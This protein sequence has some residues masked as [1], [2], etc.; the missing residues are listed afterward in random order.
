MKRS[1][2]KRRPL[3]D[4]VLSNLESELKDYRELDGNG[5]YFF[6]QKNGNKSW[7]L[8][9]KKPDGKWSWLG[10]GGYPEIGGKL[11]RKKAQEL[12]A[13]IGKGENPVI[14][15]QERKRKELEN[16]NATFEVLAKEW[17]N[18]K[19]NRWTSNT[20]TR[21]KGALEKHIFPTFGKRLYTT[22]RP[23]EWMNHLKGI[24]QEHKIFEQV[25]R[26]RAMCRDIYDYAKVTG[27]IDYNPL[28]GLQK[29]LEQG[30]KKNMAH[31]DEKELPQLLRAIDNYPTLD[32]RIGLKLLAIL[33]CRPS[34]LRE[35]TWAEF[36]LENA[37]W[38]IPEQ[39][40]K[41]RREHIIPLSTQA[42][43]L[44][45]ELKPLSGRSE[46]LFPSRS[47]SHKPKSDTVFIM[48]LRRLGYEGRQTPHGFRHI[49]STLLNNKGFDE[50][51]IEAAL[52]H[53]KDG[54]AGVYNKAQ[55]LNDRKYIMQWYADHL[56]HL[57][58]DQIIQFKRG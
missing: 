16:N 3:S 40:M 35:A 14:T 49:A 34:E 36:D 33:F 25:N 17:L 54:V 2:I 8:R 4:T 10:I 1:E 38:N 53:V 15:K 23:I 12:I 22:I 19:Q 43:Q 45:H 20:M 28:E 6:V 39:R 56:E 57:M 51:H 37:V 24:Q 55:Y 48:A 46:Y 26:I 21:N 47:N 41:K 42:V 52:A 31:V 5:L 44:L 11:A 13:D 58:D 9:Y 18:T 50:R 32:S 7:Q 30:Q 29:F 27:R